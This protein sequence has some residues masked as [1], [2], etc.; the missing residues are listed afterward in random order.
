M[1][2]YIVNEKLG[3]IPSGIEIS[4]KYRLTMF[5]DAGFKTMMI[6]TD[7]TQNKSIHDY[8][9]ELGLS[10]D[11]IDL[12]HYLTNRPPR[13]VTR[14]DW[15]IIND[16]EAHRFFYEDTL[17]YKE[18]Y[19]V[20]GGFSELTQRVF[21]DDFGQEILI[22]YFQY[23]N[24]A[25]DYQGHYYKTHQDLLVHFYNLIGFKNGDVV[26]FDRVE[27]VAPAFFF[28]VASQKNIKSY[29]NIMSE[30]MVDGIW[31]PGYKL[32]PYLSNKVTGFVVNTNAQKEALSLS[33]K[34][35]DIEM[36]R[37]YVA[38]MS[39]SPSSHPKAYHTERK[40]FITASRLAPE[41]NLTALI[42]QVSRA[43]DKDDSITLDIYGEGA[44]HLELEKMIQ[45]KPY[46][47]LKG[48]VLSKDIPYYQ[49]KAYVSTSF[50]EGLGNTLLE[51]LSQGT[52]PIA[53]NK[54]YGA[55]E[56]I[57]QGLSGILY[58]NLDDLADI[59]VQFPNQGFQSGSVK[60]ACDYHFSVV[61]S[62]WLTLL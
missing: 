62:R 22:Q 35:N 50:G 33:L 32:L 8:Y 12:F 24:T 15:K 34:Q 54:P 10:G 58:D 55:P 29:I 61:Q 37:I 23:N 3:A 2:V 19:E 38:Q 13:K 46:I 48:H 21:Y 39:S 47:R 31:N 14:D 53:W 56:I 26:F 43:H 52:P 44:E 42:D 36:D 4:E 40:G 27:D 16:I 60:R 28:S 17:F 20:I 18:I 1:T 7:L 59:L 6:F 30:H 5:Q 41:K 57:Q 45:D 49:Y 51:A 9:E 25:Y 11:Y